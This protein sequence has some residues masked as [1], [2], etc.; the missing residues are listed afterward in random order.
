MTHTTALTFNISGPFIW[1]PRSYGRRV[2]MC[3]CAMGLYS[4]HEYWARWF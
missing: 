2:P 4:V 3:T 1:C